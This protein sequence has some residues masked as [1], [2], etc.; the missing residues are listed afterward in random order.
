MNS[1][2]PKLI[3]SDID[4]TLLNDKRVL[5]EKTKQILPALKIPIILASSRMPSAMTHLQSE[6]NTDR[7]AM[8]C[9]NGAYIIDDGEVLHNTTITTDIAAFVYSKAGMHVSLYAK[10]RWYVAQKDAWTIREIN[11]TKTEPEVAIPGNVLKQEKEGFHK[12]MCMGDPEKIDTLIHH[13]K[14]EGINELHLYRS[15][16]TYL[17][18]APSSISKASALSVLLEKTGIRQAETIAFGDNYNDIDLL[19]YAGR[20]VAVANAIEEVKAIA[21]DI[22]DSG[23]DDGVANYL[24]QWVD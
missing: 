11:N 20:G 16:S 9:Y 17:E 15:K 1:F 10:D 22:T 19:K 7:Q 14:S 4:G 23:K 21:D 13:I 6:L 3:C 2:K 5:S 24:A 18:I 12:I 8:I